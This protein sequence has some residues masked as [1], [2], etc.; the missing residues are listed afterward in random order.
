MT[1]TSAT[2][3]FCGSPF[4]RASDAHQAAHRLDDQVIAREIAAPPRAAKRADRTVD[5][6]W[7]SRRKN[8]V[9]ESKA[10]HDPGSEILDNHISLGGQRQRLLHPGSLG[11]QVER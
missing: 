4:G 7:V 3:T 10:L 8:V 1:S 9:A 11:A 6:R 2:P 5:E